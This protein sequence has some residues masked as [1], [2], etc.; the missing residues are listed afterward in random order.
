MPTFSDDNFIDDGPLEYNDDS[1]DSEADQDGH[2]LSDMADE[3][4]EVEEDVQE[5]DINS[6][7]GDCVDSD[8]M[9]D[10]DRQSDVIL[11]VSFF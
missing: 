3:A 11:F 9:D 6:E 10:S 1:V 2:P 5:E 7:E 4:G 8:A